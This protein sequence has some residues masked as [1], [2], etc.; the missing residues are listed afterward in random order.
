MATSR[1]SG[2]WGR[3]G[4][5]RLAYGQGAIELTPRQVSSTG[6]FGVSIRATVSLVG[7]QNRTAVT[8]PTIVLQNALVNLTGRGN[9]GRTGAFVIS[10][11]GIMLEGDANT[12][13]LGEFVVT[14]AATVQLVGA[15]NISRI[16]VAEFREFWQ[17]LPAIPES[18]WQQLPNP[19][20]S[21]WQQLPDA[22]VL[23]WTDQL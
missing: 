13:R 5:G 6:E 9:V 10:D 8:N 2:G 23:T 7:V 19:A 4:W 15:Q 21:A 22:Q 14:I 3:V 18:P 11:S 17:L 20:T 12:A 16:G 1:L